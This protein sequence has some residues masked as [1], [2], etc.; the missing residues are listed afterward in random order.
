MFN[1]PLLVLVAV[2]FKRAQL[3]AVVFVSADN[4]E[5][6]TVRLVLDA[7]AVDDPLLGRTTVERLQVHVLTRLY[8][9][10]RIY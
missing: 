7:V 8:R 2:M 1:A 3:G 5:H 9:H 6:F 4:V 10:H